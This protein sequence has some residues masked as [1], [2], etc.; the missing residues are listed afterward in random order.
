[1]YRTRIKICGVCRF[2]DALLAAE[3]GA[4]AI[5]IVLHPASARNVP[6]ELAERIVAALPP[7][8]T[9]VGVFVDAP[10]EHVTA[11]ARRLGLRHVQ[12]NGNEGPADV[13]EIGATV[14]KAVRVERSTFEA[15]LSRWRQAKSELDL[16]NL[17]GLV[18]EPAGTSAPG[19][20]GVAND[21]ETV[22]LARRRGLFDGLPGLIAAGGLTTGTVASVVRAVRPWAVDVSTGVEVD[23]QKGRK[24][25]QKLRAF[26]QAVREA[27]GV[28][29]G[30]S[31]SRGTPGEGWGE[32]S[33][34]NRAP[35]S[36]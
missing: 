23:G 24:S 8:V 17:A 36:V 35:P 21:W 20:T 5:G 28:A 16:R 30:L 22:A 12:L 1:V 6:L 31:P 4:D 18:L 34:G 29:A 26:V 19:G 14:I 9:P 25:E 11:V 2:E 10:A 7:F 33:D 27:D 15:Q 32:G 13:R 3:V